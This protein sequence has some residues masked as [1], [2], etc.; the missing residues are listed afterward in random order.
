M[1]MNNRPEIRPLQTVTFAFLGAERARLSP[2]CRFPSSRPLAYPEGSNHGELPVRSEQHVPSSMETMCR[3]QARSM[4]QSLP[5]VSCGRGR[6][7][8]IVL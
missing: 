5:C 8:T 6:S 4:L 7:H 1:N 2:L 3:I